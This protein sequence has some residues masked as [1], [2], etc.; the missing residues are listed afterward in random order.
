M[1]NNIYET[2]Q[3]EDF[4]ICFKA[5]NSLLEEIDISAIEISVA[6]INP[7]RN[8]IYESGTETGISIIRDTSSSFIVSISSDTTINMTPGDYTLSVMLT[9]DN[10][11][12]IEQIKIIRLIN[13]K[14]R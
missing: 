5:K 6:L 9:K 14:H 1:D 2:F 8:Q 4:E 12:A 7:L 11:T 13:S 10:K 3:G